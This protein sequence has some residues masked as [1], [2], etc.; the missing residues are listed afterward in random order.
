MLFVDRARRDCCRAWSNWQ[1]SC[2]M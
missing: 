2:G 1:V